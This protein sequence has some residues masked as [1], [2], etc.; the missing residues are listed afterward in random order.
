MSSPGSEAT[1][2]CP[3]CGCEHQP[4]ALDGTPS[5]TTFEKVEFHDFGIVAYPLNDSRLGFDKHQ[6]MLFQRIGWEAV[7]LALGEALASAAGSAA[8]ERFLQ[9]MGWRDNLSDMLAKT[10][11]ALVSVPV[12]WELDTFI[13]TVDHLS[14]QMQKYNRNPANRYDDLVD[15]E[16]TANLLCN[17]LAI[18]YGPHTRTLYSEV[19][20]LE[21]SCIQQRINLG[22]N[23]QATFKDRAS[24]HYKIC[25]D[26]G[27]WWNRTVN[28]RF[29][30]VYCG[31]E[32]DL[33]T[34][35]MSNKGQ[36]SCGYTDRLLNKNYSARR[37]G[38]QEAYDYIN[39][40]RT[41]QVRHAENVKQRIKQPVDHVLGQWL[42]V[43]DSY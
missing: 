41:N 27:H 43:A 23:E 24:Y 34:D 20:S 1:V 15:A 39:S 33:F 3:K 30:W 13:A 42:A 36:W 2:R 28:D 26:W 35:P 32:G 9:I 37:H 8:I 16:R 38:R 11:A 12:N 31:E 22:Q 10:Q 18:H 14:Q 19:A 25:D 40:H 17:L 4:E 5:I 21:L 6:P 29:T 7:A